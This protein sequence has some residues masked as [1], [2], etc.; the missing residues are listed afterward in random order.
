MPWNRGVLMK[1]RAAVTLA[2]WG[3][4]LGIVYAQTQK[5]TSKPLAST[6]LDAAGIVAEVIESSR[7]D[8]VLTV[9]VRFRNTGDKT[10]SLTLA[11]AGQYDDNYISAAKTKYA[12]VRDSNG[13][14]IATPMNP[15]GELSASIPKGKTWNWWA[16]F[17]APPAEVKTYDLYLKVGP[18]IEEIPIL[19]K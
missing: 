16:K 9:R 14:V 1:T 6:E 15:G 5:S 17:T 11:T 13:Y 4:S 7:K 10:A 12:V 18:P 8:N 2:L 19:E 3:I